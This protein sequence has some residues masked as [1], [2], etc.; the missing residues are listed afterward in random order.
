MATSATLELS[1]KSSGAV[2]SLK[3]VEKQ[4]G[5]VDK[6]ADK[7]KKKLNKGGGMFGGMKK[8]LSG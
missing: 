2:K 8:G 4:L 5:K 6:Q 3:N 1:V 7:T